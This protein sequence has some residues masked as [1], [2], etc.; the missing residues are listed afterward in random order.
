VT[1]QIP[2]FEKNA[3]NQQAFNKLLDWFDPDHDKAALIY[4]RSAYG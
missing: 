2:T 1:E 3:L 4:E